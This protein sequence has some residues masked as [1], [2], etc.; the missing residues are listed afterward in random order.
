MAPMTSEVM[1]LGRVGGVGRG[2]DAF[3]DI[4]KEWRVRRRL[5]QAALAHDAEV[6]ARHLSFLETGKARPSREMVLVLASAL[7]LPLRE[8]NALLSSAGFAAAY[9]EE[10]LDDRQ[11]AF[12]RRALDQVLTRMEPNAVALLDRH[13]NLV[14][15][16][17]T[18]HLVLSWLWSPRPVPARVNVMR[19]AFDPDALRPYVANLAVIGPALV[20]VLQREARLDEGSRRLLAEVLAFPPVPRR[21]AASASFPVVPLTFAKDGVTLS[22]FSTIAVLGTATDAGLDN[23]R[24]ETYFP[25]DEATERFVASLAG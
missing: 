18:L 14:Q 12:V 17:R 3:G 9:R 21:G 4:L 22:V 16:N 6:S 25:A 5:S 1:T 11:L 2:M 24:I 13:W 10:P 20:E 23:L 8:R 15:G 19:D 7:E